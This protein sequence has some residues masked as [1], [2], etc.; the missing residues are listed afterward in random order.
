MNRIQRKLLKTHY[1]DALSVGEIPTRWVF[2]TKHYMIVSAKGRGSRYRSRTD[3]YGFPNRA[4]PR[5][6]YVA[7]FIS[8]DMVKANVPKGKNR[9]VHVGFCSMRSSG[10]ADVR[11]VNGKNIAAG[12][13]AKYFKVI[14]RFDG[15]SYDKKVTSF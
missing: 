13:Y 7:G 14:Q 1:F 9:G 10:Y 11:D 4:M 12:V 5:T 2:R 15:Y 8:G 3:K 6:K